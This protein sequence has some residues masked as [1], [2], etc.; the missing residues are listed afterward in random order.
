MSTEF[1]NDQW[2][3]PSNE[4]QNKISNYS[5]DKVLTNSKILSADSSVNGTSDISVSI[6]FKSTTGGYV[7]S[8]PNTDGGNGFDLNVNSASARVYFLGFGYFSD[9]FNYIDGNW[10]HIV[11]T[12]NGATLKFYTDGS[13][14]GSHSVTTTISNGLNLF[15]VGAFSPSYLTLG[16]T[17]S[18]DQTTIFD[19]ALSQDQVK[20][21]GGEGYA[22]NFIPNDYID[23]GTNPFSF[24]ENLSVSLWVKSTQTATNTFIGKDVNTSGGRNW[25]VM[26]YQNRVYFWTTST[27]NISNLL[28]IQSSVA[29]GVT[30]G[31][32]HHIV[33]VNNYTDSTKQIY[34]DGVLDITN[35]NGGAIS[36]SNSPVQIGKRPSGFPYVGEMSNVAVWN[37]ALT[38]SKANTLYNNGKPGNIS[39]LNPTAW[40]K[41][42]DSEIFN[43][44]STEWSVDNNAL[45]STYKSSLDFDGGSDWVNIS[46][47]TATTFNNL[48]FSGWLNWDNTQYSCPFAFSTLGGTDTG[49]GFAIE[50]RE[51]NNG[52]IRVAIQ[53]SGWLVSTAVI[54]RDTWFHIAVT[55]SPTGIIMYKDGVEILNSTA[56]NS[57]N[58]QPV[59]ES[60]AIGVR[61]Y[62]SLSPP[63]P[64][65]FG[66]TLSNI[67]LWN[68]TLTAPQI[69]TLYNNGTPEASISHS[70]LSWWKLNNTAAGIQD[71]GS[72]SN[73]G[74]NVGATEYAGFVNVSAGDSVGMDASNLVVSNI[75]GELISNPMALNPKP[76]A[77][78][79]L[80]DQSVDNGANYLVPNNSLSDY[81]FDFDG[82]NDYID[83]GVN[84]SSSVPSEASSWTFS[85]WLYLD[86][87]HT[88][89]PTI[90]ERGAAYPGDGIMVRESGG[91]IQAYSGATLVQF[92]TLTLA[93]DKWN[94]FSLTWEKNT[95]VITCYINDSSQ[96]TTQPAGFAVTGTLFNIGKRQNNTGFW[97]GQ[98]S[99]V[100]IFNTALSTA[101]IETLYNNGSPATDI[102]SLSPVAWYKLNASEIFNSTSTE[103]SIDNNAYPS[104][105][106]SSLNFDGSDSIDCGNITALNS[107][108]SISTSAWIN[109]S[110]TLG[111]EHIF[112]SGGSS[113]SNRFYVQLLSS[114]QIRYGSGSGSDIVTIS[115][116]SS[117]SWHH[118]VTVHNG[119]SL[120]IYLDGVKQNASPV[121][122]I[123]PNTNIGN[124]FT[125]GKYF[126]GGL[127]WNGQL[128][129][130]SVFNIGLSS[131]QVQALYN[132]GTPQASISSSP[133]SWYK[134]NNTTTGIQD[135]AG[136]NN[137]TNNGT[138]EYAGFVNALA[139]DSVGMISANLVTSD[140]QQTSG[141]SPYALSL[142]GGGEFMYTNISALTSISTI[143]TSMWVK[144]ATPSFGYVLG[145]LGNNN[146]QI[147]I[148]YNAGK[149]FFYTG[150]TVVY[151]ANTSSAGVWYN[152]VLTRAGD[153]QKMYI[154]GALQATATGLT[155]LSL[156]D[157]VLI[158]KQNNGYNKDA[159]VS[160]LAIWSSELT[161]SQITTLY[162]QGLPSNL[163]TF[164]TKPIFWSQFGTNSSFNASANRWTSIDEISGNNVLSHTVM[165]E[166]DI[167][168]GPGYSGN[169][170]GSSS[171]DIV[172]DAPYSTANGLS[173]NMDV[174]DRTLDTPIINT[175]SIQLDGIDDYIDFGNVN[176][177][178]R[179]DAFSGSCWV[180]NEGAS[181]NQ[182]I[183]AKRNASRKGYV[184]YFNSSGALVCIIG[185]GPGSDVSQV[186][187]AAPSTNTWNHLAFTY[188][189]S[190]TRAGMKL[191]VNGALQ[192]LTYYGQSTIT[193][194]IKDPNTPF[195]ISGEDG[196][197]GNV[198]KGKIDEVAMFNSELSAPQVA[199]I[200]NN[201]VPNNILPLNPV[202]WHRFESLT[203]NGGVVTTADDS[204]NGLTGTVENGAVLSTNVP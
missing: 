52:R 3:I 109:Y 75:N 16:T 72:A 28:A 48:S 27:G 64:Q 90:F 186:V 36:N 162:N 113:S 7:W 102:S 175:H 50:V 100:S 47:A 59:Y 101:N 95:N 118:I 184:L 29:G 66:G 85:A 77:Y 185:P 112:I 150:V 144:L 183:I 141:Y 87:T 182:Y 22:F 117:G 108:S 151:A 37:T 203:T 43:T 195:Q 168:N 21:L 196:S 2:R 97:K 96:S 174:L 120:D 129:N 10:H 80:G 69:T 188:D 62:F 157:Y 119:T 178:E 106:Q 39:S 128:S 124:D 67:A 78:Y 19:Y 152:I 94:Y 107:Q 86:S 58:R 98:M 74:T 49:T 136:S 111:S 60:A 89:F 51:P 12:Y 63:Y 33:C 9:S 197:T 170:L 138:T 132:N 139:G 104:V 23:L 153:T 65:Y 61:S 191:Y 15:F 105:Y 161:T 35:G 103:W 44:A 20:I 110:G 71:S 115:T 167:V 159:D 4:N 79:Q 154:N 130:T 172:G 81:V 173:E 13:L 68:T 177:F 25:M 193:G 114:T 146:T 142:S 122:V 155:T 73:N 41:L 32:W 70:P 145:I 26:L 140:L 143:T 8:F 163:S 18:Y 55:M 91:I 200:Y 166:D 131:A 31:R 158:G 160:N 57:L 11:V 82:S 56:T 121:T 126:L 169:G 38:L 76:V 189:G 180:F 201:G 54:P 30:D 93:A 147:S 137:G 42:D 194:T 198:L 83:L 6:W 187:A 190:S 134:L 149:F 24:T 171:I 181:V 46:S 125:I 116:I 127:E 135:S 156:N 199:S 53:G 179:T 1:F 14:N 202:S 123:A 40:Y 84:S 88:S 204:G 165:S 17:G 5:M 148:G 133:V 45:P 176:I 99:N 192:S 92:N 164:S 34:I